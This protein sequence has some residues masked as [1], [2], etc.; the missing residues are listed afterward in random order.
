MKATFAIAT[1]LATLAAASPARSGNMLP[2][3]ARAITPDQF[4]K[5]WCAPDPVANPVCPLGAF[6]VR[7]VVP[8]T[9]MDSAF[10]AAKAARSLDR[11]VDDSVYQT[12]VC[13]SYGCSVYV[14]SRGGDWGD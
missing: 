10:H 13:E 1:L 5:R 14:K 3:E 12:E 9:A 6:W 7:L 2:H 4:W 8:P 11:P